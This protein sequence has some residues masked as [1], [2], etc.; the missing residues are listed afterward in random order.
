M[1]NARRNTSKYYGYLW[2]LK[3][4]VWGNSYFLHVYFDFS[5]YFTTNVFYFTIKK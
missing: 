2:C 3:G 5:K 4:G 1:E